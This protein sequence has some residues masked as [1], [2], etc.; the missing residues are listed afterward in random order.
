M[1]AILT[2]HLF[3]EGVIDDALDLLGLR[4]ADE[5]DAFLL[6]NQG[7]DPLFYLFA[8]PLMKKWLPLGHVMHDARPAAL[9]SALREA[10]ER[11]E[12]RGR[13]I[14][15]AYVAGFVCHW[16]LD[17]SMHPYIYCWQNGLCAAGVPGLDERDASK[18]HAEIERDLDETVLY[19]LVG[20]TV[21]RYRPHER[22]LRASRSVL[23]VVDKVYFYVALWA[24]GR[25]IDPR[26]FSTAVREFR[27]V[28]T[29]LDSPTGR[30]RALLGAAERAFA[31]T[32]YSLAYAMSHRVRAE[33]AS[34]FDNREGRAWENPFTGER[35]TASF[36]DIYEDAQ[37][38]VL[39]TLDEL[40]SPG[41]D[42]AAARELTGDVN[43]EGAVS[44][45]D[46]SFAWE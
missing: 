28:Q 27:L 41:F 46:A 13:T 5:K 10:C 26:T 4:T 39:G 1:P 45:P 12:G 18:V 24:Y 3:G 29:A 43:F 6:G 17:S 31:R 37:S 9:L 16:L 44:A 42:R 20:Q 19:S 34:A 25:P 11:I 15:K 35:S 21:E 22:V 32:P 2:H 23:A 38:R 40:F 30:K 14:A 7:P 36:W 8:D 33:S